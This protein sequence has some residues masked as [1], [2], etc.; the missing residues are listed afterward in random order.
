[1]VEQIKQTFLNVFLFCF[2]QKS[3]FNS[4]VSRLYQLLSL[5][6]VSDAFSTYR[7]VQMHLFILLH[8]IACALDCFAIENCFLHSIASQSRT[9][10]AH[11]VC[12]SA[13]R[14]CAVLAQSRV[15]CCT[16]LLRNSIACAIEN[17]FRTTKLCG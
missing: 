2:N 8:S 4:D 5:N 9:L 14:S 1:M 13:Q 17:C 3:N 12:G 6:S 10:S 11:G 15:I 7:K 16:R